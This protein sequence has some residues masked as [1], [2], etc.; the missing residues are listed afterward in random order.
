MSFLQ[1]PKFW[2][3]KAGTSPSR[4]ERWLAPFSCVYYFFYTLHQHSNTPYVSD[5]P[6][7]CLGNLV[8]GGTGKTPAAL[9]ILEVIKDRELAKT[10]F[11]L[12]RGYG[13]AERGPLLVEATRHTSWDVGDEPLI[14]CKH[15]PTVVST[16]RAKGVKLAHEKGADLII[17]DDGLQNPGIHKDIKL[18]VINGEMG[19]GNQKMLPA[20]PLRQPL[21]KGL[22]N[23]DGF[24]L[25][26][27]DVRGLTGI[28]PTDKPIIK[29]NIKPQ[30]GSVLPDKDLR[31]FAFAGLGYPEK[32][33]SFLKNT[34][35]LNL[36]ETLKFA[37]HYPYT[38]N[39][40]LTLDRKAKALDARLITTEKDFMRLP[41]TENITVDVVNV[42]MAF[43]NTD[44][45]ARLIESMIRKS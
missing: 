18:I 25:I 29:A 15:A 44:L 12:S 17:M 6:V 27:E 34:I 42:E 1:T 45:L 38:K 13:G 16:D 43:E 28:L 7:L 33:F 11:F 9:A 5:I 40:L 14:L 37:D 32:F 22:E 26:G 20:G 10:P 8:T 36:V 39:D 19:F 24:I 2:Y 23:A 21:T 3:I 30:K 4:L 31:Y 35:N 41:A